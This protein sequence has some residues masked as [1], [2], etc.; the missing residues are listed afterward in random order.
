MTATQKRKEEELSSV[1]KSFWSKV[2]TDVGLMSMAQP[3]KIRAKTEYRPRVKQY[4]LK[5]DAEE[6]I[7]NPCESP[8]HS[9]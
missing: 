2:K 5:P 7:R 9:L 4:P 6:G 1:P 3:V 8:R